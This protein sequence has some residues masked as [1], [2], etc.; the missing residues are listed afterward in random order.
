MPNTA[1]YGLPYPALS[2]SP[3][4]PVAFANLAN[5]IDGLG[6]IGGKRR[7]GDSS[8]I[9]TI[10][11]IVIDTQTLAL[12]ANSVFEIAYF[13]NIINSTSGT[14]VEMR[15]RQTSVSGTVLG[16]CVLP[17][18]DQINWNPGYVCA[19]YKTTSAEL[20]YFCG[21]LV[22]T[23]GTGTIIAKVPTS[24]IVTNLGPSSIIGDF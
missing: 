10:E 17:R 15:I 11:S 12:A 3:N 21:T 23:V 18:S 5:A 20:Q 24:L 9:T 1:K 4:G 8:S 7:T 6:V 16:D 13:V 14:D 22:R 2:D 19:I